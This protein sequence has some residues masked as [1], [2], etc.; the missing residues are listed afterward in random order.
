MQY[1]DYLTERYPE[2]FVALDSAFVV[3][4]AAEFA[5]ADSGSV[6][7]PA[8]AGSEYVV[9]FAEADLG[10]VALA[11]IDLR[12]EAGTV[13]AVESDQDNVAEVVEL[14]VDRV[15]AVALDPG[16]AEHG[17]PSVVA[18]SVLDTVVAEDALV[19]DDIGD[20]IVAVG[21]VVGTVKQ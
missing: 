13:A 17:R 7:G 5:E 14:E 15:V 9:E 16:I 21:N 10:I 18:V 6:A 3:V 20:R 2:Y 4:F 8:E 1:F 12:T 19:A 11:A